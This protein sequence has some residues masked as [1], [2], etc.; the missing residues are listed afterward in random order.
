[1]SEFISLKI[2]IECEVDTMNADHKLF[3]ES[4]YVA[5]VKPRMSRDEFKHTVFSQIT[6]QMPSYQNMYGENV[7]WFPVAIIDVY[8]IPD[9]DAKLERV[10][11]EVFS[12]NIIMS[13]GAKMN[14]V[15]NK[16][17]PDYVWEDNIDNE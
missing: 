4:V 11:T 3:E 15:I 5:K 9:F 12:R 7:K 10:F 17:Y 2:L 16:F 13:A 14:D 1:M 8:E 6:S